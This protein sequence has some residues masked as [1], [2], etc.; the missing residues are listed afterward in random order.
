MTYYVGIDLGT[1]NSAIC[2]FDGS[3]VRIWK[4]IEQ[5]DVTPSAIYIDKRGNS[6]YGA[7][8]YNQ[9]PYYPDDSATLFKRF[10]GTNNKINF[11]SAKISMS[12]EECSAEIL[13]YLF[14][15]L[16]EEIRTNND[17]ATIITVPAAFNQMKKD[18]TLR[19][20]K[21]AGF[22]KVTL[23]QE[24][25]AAIMSVMRTT[26]HE[27]VF[28]IYDLGGGT[29]DVSIAQSI[30]GKVNLLAH[31]GIEMCGGRDIDRMI[32]KNT[33]VPW[34]MDNYNLPDDLISNTKYKLLCRVAIWAAER[35]KIELSSIENTVINLSEME[36]RTFD[37]DGEEI[38][39][40]IPFNRKQ[41]DSFLKEIINDTVNTT[42][43]TMNKA[44][45]TANDIEKIVFIGGPVN[46]KPLRDMVS[47][48]LS[49]PPSVDTNPM[50]AVAE[51]A[52]IF[53]EAINWDDIQHNRK[54]LS[55]ELITDLD[56][57]FRYN[58]R[59]SDDN[60]KIV[61]ILNNEIKTMQIEI[62]SLDSGWTSGR[63]S[64]KQN[65]D[66]DVPLIKDG[67]NTFLV[68]VY[69]SVGQAQ[70][71][72]NNKIIITKTLATIGAIPASH[73]ISLEARNKLGGK[74][75]LIKL[76]EEGVSLSEKGSVK[77]R[78]GKTIKAGTNE[79]L[80]FKLWEGSLDTVT[81]NTYIGDVKLSGLDFDE[82]II[83]TGTEIECSYE[84]S[85]SGNISFEVAVPSI[86]VIVANKNLYSAQEG[87]NKLDEN[88]E[89]LAEDIENLFNRID[90]LSEKIDDERLVNAREKAEKAVEVIESSSDKEDLQKANQAINESKKA[91]NQV[92]KENINSVRQ[93]ELAS[94]LEAFNELVREYAN[95]N[96]EQTY[97][98]LARKAEKSIDRNSPDFENQLDE[99]KSRNFQILW[100][101]DWF[102]VD[103]FNRLSR[104]PYNYFD[105]VKFEE[106]IK[107]GQK[108]LKDDD[109][110][111]LRQVVVELS[112]IQIYTS[113]DDPSMFDTNIIKE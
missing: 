104:N 81:D 89:K 72:K 108:K 78:A 20:A 84:M 5:N 48:E 43:E 42:K 67:D 106:L 29:F 58:S 94:C 23:M 40:D 95:Q 80:N 4:S 59:I 73:T 99:L 41:K 107:S 21:L 63:A 13:K 46:Y 93:M 3:N 85:D 24:P 109:I 77:V 86:G 83:S 28:L 45:L 60:A 25:V 7:R 64:L 14:G 55:G 12:P 26:K 8:A 112:R 71:L 69:N 98:N 92:R 52:S 51:G 6:Y 31:G 39:I 33:I 68:N 17:I 15:Y 105:R 47:F 32:F 75:I 70:T 111:G 18:A 82:G 102:V 16:P 27:G 100:R 35:A 30:G 57:S 97:Y 54:A 87:Q 36:T 53:A 19:A 74:E 96:E 103:W 22:E 101:Q 9:A 1:T 88:I 56:V 61:C 65:L 2:T 44:G 76:I 37:L 91:F 79:T 50:T 110:D 11:K 66:F 62:T 34:L 38:I 49:L 90:D 10:M 113:T